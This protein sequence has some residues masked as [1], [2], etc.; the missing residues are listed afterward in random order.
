MPLLRALG[1]HND[2]K[3][4]IP[5]DARHLVIIC[6]GNIMRS[7]MSEALFKQFAA[8]CHQRGVS[9]ISGG[10][11]AVPG[12]SVDPRALRV[13]PLFR[14]A[15]ENSTARILIP[16]MGDQAAVILSMDCQNRTLVRARDCQCAGTRIM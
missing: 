12:R 3:S 7:P 6:H 11:N 15:G 1:L 13:A 2:R 8:D 4:K 5:P 9:V 10:V 14:I 16:S